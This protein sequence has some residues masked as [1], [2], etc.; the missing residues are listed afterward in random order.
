MRNTSLRQSSYAIAR[1]LLHLRRP[2]IAATLQ[3]RETDTFQKSAKTLP[4]PNNRNSAAGWQPTPQRKSR[5]GTLEMETWCTSW[6][7]LLN[8]QGKMLARSTGTKEG[9]AMDSD[10]GRLLG[11]EVKL[12]AATTRTRRDPLLTTD[13]TST[14]LRH[15]FRRTDS[16]L[17][18]FSPV[19]PSPVPDTGK[20]LARI[21]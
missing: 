18:P 7:R 17:Y 6:R 4:K 2:A 10:R 3:G 11:V 1:A 8:M 16:N 13:A 5:P 19:Y 9:A 15:R 21:R 20:I 12:P 14:R